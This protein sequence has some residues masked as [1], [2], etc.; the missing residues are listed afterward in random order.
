MT[1]GTSPSDAE[2][3]SQRLV[4]HVRSCSDREIRIPFH[5]GENRS[6]T[7]VLTR[8]ATGLRLKHDHRHEDGSEDRVTQYGGDSAGSAEALR[9][10][11]PADA[12]TANLIPAAATNV[13]TMEIDPR[14][15]FTYALARANRRFRVDFDLT[16]AVPPPPPPW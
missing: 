3:G 6:R 4:M 15:R 16:R 5:V 1:E 11:F 12:F 10:D 13:W 8:T 7:W 14:R 9:V 2:I